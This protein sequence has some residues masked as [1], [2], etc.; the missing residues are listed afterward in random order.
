ML[1]AS[2]I[3]LLTTV[4][5]SVVLWL[6]GIQQP[7]LNGFFKLWT[8]FGDGIFF[9]L[10]VL[11]LLIW[12]RHHGIMLLAIGISQGVISALMK[13]VLFK[14]TPR[15]RKF[16]E[17]QD[18]LTFIEGVKV[19]DYHSFPSG[20]TMSAFALAT[21]LSLMTERKDLKTIL[22]VGAILVAVSRMYLN[23]HFLVDVV[24]GSLIGVILSVLINKYANK[25]FRK[26]TATNAADD[27]E[28]TELEVRQ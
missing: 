16:F 5:G 9:G 14:G 28:I 24:V 7:F 11:V 13:R 19:H 1:V 26:R 6:N 18:V 8:H 27:A 22:L 23:Q 21:F 17:G 4:H 25:Y 10:I 15:P 2:G 20:H 3:L 12:R